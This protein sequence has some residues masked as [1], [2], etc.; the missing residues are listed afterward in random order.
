MAKRA[1]AW[2]AY[3]PCPLLL[4]ELAEAAVLAHGTREYDPEARLRDP[5]DIL[6]VC[7]SLIWH[8]D[9]TDEVVLAHHSVKDFLCSESARARAEYYHLEDISSNAEIAK[10]CL[11]YLLLKDF[12]GGPA[13][14]GQELM[15]RY[16]QYPLLDFAAR[17]WC[18]Q[19]VPAISGNEEL[20]S[21][22]ME[23]MDPKCT[24]ISWR[25]SKSSSQ[26]LA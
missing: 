2:L 18:G 4:D 16:I 19:A 14:S 24:P 6:E 12:A 17:H 20:H 11:T 15:K 23:L 13:R 22:A 3:A 25:G 9:T 5:E 21:L 26:I 7:G 8:R 1:L 10:S